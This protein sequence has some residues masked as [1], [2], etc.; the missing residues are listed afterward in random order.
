MKHPHAITLMTLLLAG[1]AA[2][3][4]EKTVE[5]VHWWTSGSEGAA[6]KV[7]KDDVVKRG[8][9]WK[10]S[11]VAGGGGDNARTALKARV[12]SG[13][14]PDAM[15]MLGYSITEYAEEGLLG[16]VDAVAASEGWDKV[17]PQ[18]LQKFAKFKGHW[19]AAPV[20]IH[21]TNWIWA[22][23]A[24]F[25]ELKLTPP[26]TFDELVAM[27]DKIRKAGYIPLAH[28]GQPWQDATLFDSAVMSAGGPKFYKEA[29]I[30][31][32]PKALSGKTMEKAFEQ[33]QKLRTMVDPGYMGR[34]W[35]FATSMIYHKKAAMQIM[36][37]WA[38]GEF[39]K[40]KMKPNQDFLCFQYPGTEGSF[41]FNADQFGFLKVSEK[42]MA[43][44]A[45]LASA[46][47]DKH[48]Q[49][50]FNQVKG[51]IPART[52]VAMDGFDECGKK[53]MNDMKA[54]L[55]NNTMVGSFAHG[56]AMHDKAK[57]AAT[58]VVARFFDSGT[59]PAEAAKQLAAAVAGAK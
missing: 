5:V 17:V 32:D 59:S 36:G 37:D 4:Q 35:N 22:N 14:P 16:N 10:D 44:Q 9:N 15:Q 12:A 51:S 18:P 20:N 49:E 6:L 43:G 57:A 31:L 56:H 13:S 53:S 24:I 7:L 1:G 28:G 47:M 52:D 54:A 11:A 55:K 26:K 58:E 3:A 29:L 27:A 23:K 40:G 25:D 30:D 38:K 2:T 50:K 8:F 19:V 21:R 42:Q 33:M 34:E 41:I 46:V 48:F 45:A 39:E